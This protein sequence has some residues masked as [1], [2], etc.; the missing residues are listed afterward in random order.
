[1]GGNGRIQHRGALNIA[2]VFMAAP[3][4]DDNVHIT[5][6]LDREIAQIYRRIAELVGMAV[7]KNQYLAAFGILRFQ[8]KRHILRGLALFAVHQHAHLA[9]GLDG[10]GNTILHHPPLAW[11]L[12]T[13][14]SE[15]LVF[16]FTQLNVHGFKLGRF[17]HGR[18]LSQFRLWATF[19]AKRAGDF[20]GA[21]SFILQLDQFVA[22]HFDFAI[23]A[24]GTSLITAFF[25][26]FRFGLKLADTG[27]KAMNTMGQCINMFFGERKRRGSVVASRAIV[28]CHFDLRVMA[29]MCSAAILPSPLQNNE[30]VASSFLP[31]HCE[32]NQAL[33]CYV[34][35]ESGINLEHFRSK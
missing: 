15:A 6:T 30:A 13:D 8:A 3:F 26:R 22:K 10:L 32:P 5:D 18:N 35:H 34:H 4:A 33:I 16:C 28:R 1:M 14:G 20:R 29:D 11:P 2:A 31:S 17:D 19:Q 21:G 23:K 25:H 12:A 7:T 9:K 27:I 24:G